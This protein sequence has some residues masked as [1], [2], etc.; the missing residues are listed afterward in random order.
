MAPHKITVNAI[1]CGYFLT[2]MTA[3]LAKLAGED[4]V[5]SMA[6][7]SRSG[8]AED[9]GGAALFLASNAGAWITGV[10]L[11]VDGGVLIKPQA[12]L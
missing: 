8:R 1:A 5:E 3:G 12:S 4:A 10:I 9:V 7:L 11:P 6:P 2:K